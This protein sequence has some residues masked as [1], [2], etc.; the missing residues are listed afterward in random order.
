[1]NGS[2]P[3]KTPIDN[4]KNAFRKKIDAHENKRYGDRLSCL[5]GSSTT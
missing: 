5:S 4:Y 2:A 1:M 3:P